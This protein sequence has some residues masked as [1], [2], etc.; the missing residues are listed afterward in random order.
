MKKQENNPKEKRGRGRPAGR[1]KMVVSISLDTET[2]IL[3]K[4][5]GAGWQTRVNEL[6]RSSIALLVPELPANERPKT[7]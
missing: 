4:A 3:L 2:V 1:T 6:L 7:R 5:T